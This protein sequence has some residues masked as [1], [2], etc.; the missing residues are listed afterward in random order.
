MHMPDPATT[1][2]GTLTM[3]ALWEAMLFHSDRSSDGA[4]LRTVNLRNHLASTDADADALL[5][6]L[7]SMTDGSDSGTQVGVFPA[8]EQQLLAYNDQDPAVPVS[9]VGLH[10]GIAEAD[11]PLAVSATVTGQS[12]GIVE[13]LR[14]R[15][16]SPDAVQR[17]VDAGFRPPRD[18]QTQPSELRDTQRWPDYPDP[19][20]LPDA[21]GWNTLMHLWS[22]R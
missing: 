14:A 8:T 2:E 20:E 4:A 1:T 6:E 9:L 7:A 5:S 15:L 19:V 13:Q 22:V 17:L 12:S 18:A 10:D 11:F 21:S 16:R 3:V